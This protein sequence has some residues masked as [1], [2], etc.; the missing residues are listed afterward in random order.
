MGFRFD[1]NL[2]GDFIVVNGGFGVAGCPTEDA[3]K[4]DSAKRNEKAKTLGVKTDYTVHP[5]SEGY[6][7]TKEEW[8]KKQAAK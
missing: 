4:E 5:R 7:V 1:D 3:A 2:K 8:E 6:P